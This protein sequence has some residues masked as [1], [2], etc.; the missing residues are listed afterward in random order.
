M[1]RVVSAVVGAVVCAS[2]L[3]ACG[4]GGQVA[5]TSSVPT[6]GSGAPVTSAAGVVTTTAAPEGALRFTPCV[7]I[8]C[9]TLTVPSTH[10]DPSSPALKVAVYRRAATSTEGESRG[11]LVLIPDWTGWT[12]R[13]LAEKSGIL[14]GSFTRDF[15]VVAMSPRGSY[16]SSP[17]PCGT[18]PTYVEHADDAAAIAQKCTANTA[19]PASSYGTIEAAGDASSLVEA[20]GE[21]QV[22]VL[23]WGRG[24]TIAAAWKL[25]HPEEIS[26]AVLDS[27]EDPGITPQRAAQMNLVANDAAVNA[28]MKWCTS[29]ISCPFVENAGK[30]VGFVLKDIRDGKAG[31]TTEA[32]FRLAF[33][34][35]MDSGD[36]GTLFRALAAAENDDFAPLRDFADRDNP[37]AAQAFAARVAGQCSDLAANDADAIITDDAEFEFTLFRAGF[38]MTLP[39][40]CLE[41]PESPQ[42]LGFVRAADGA[43]GALVQT[44]VANG[45]GAVSPAMVTGLSK[46]LQ[47]KNKVIRASRHLVIGFD[48]T[49]TAAAAKFLTGP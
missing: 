49:T 44:F 19:L 48:R 3:A 18:P 4:G 38:G 10:D 24:A 34:N 27:P 20:L 35:A 30:R 43:K 15:D 47:W 14:L 12:A 29:H 5:G 21:P 33:Q 36:F 46:R 13:E 39:R 25:M 17:L 22:K 2:V 41:M 40:I 1:S 23:A 6:E 26:A 42:P 37:S 45:D 11:V 8:E 16:D 28:V 7:A 32:D 31:S 9:G